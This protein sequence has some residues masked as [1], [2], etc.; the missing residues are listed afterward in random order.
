MNAT[1]RRHDFAFIADALST[2]NPPVTPPTP[3][4]NDDKDDV[5]SATTAA[6]G[7]DGIQ[8]NVHISFELNIQL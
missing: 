1:R 2:V 7:N 4:G 6:S 5:A 3:G 8:S